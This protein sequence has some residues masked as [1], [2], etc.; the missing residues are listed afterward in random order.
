EQCRIVLDDAGTAPDL[1]PPPLGIV[2]QEEEGAVVAGEVAGGDVL[3]VAAVV[4]EGQRLVVEHVDEALR[5]A[6]MLDGGLALFADG[7]EIGG[8]ALGDVGRELGRD[9]VGP[10]PRLR[11]LLVAGPRPAAVLNGFDGR[12]EGDVAGDLM[13]GCTL[14]LWM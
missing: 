1:Y 2:H 12:R 11:R 9:A 7:R 4:G 8:I 13:H 5:P 10:R 14:R 3:P 6:A